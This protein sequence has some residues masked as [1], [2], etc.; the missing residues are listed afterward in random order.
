MD[1][2]ASPSKGGAIEVRLIVYDILGREVANLIPPL[3]GGQE[4]LSPGTY[5]AVWDASNFPSGVYF[6]KLE[7]DEYSVSKKMVLIK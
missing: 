2:R 7:T 5:E 4:G 6:Y 3:R 1:I